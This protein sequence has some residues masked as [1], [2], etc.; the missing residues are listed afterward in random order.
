VNALPIISGAFGV[1][2]KEAVIEVGGY[3]RGHLGEDMELTMRLHR[4]FRRRR[5]RYRIVYAPD[6]VAWTEVPV[7]KDVLRKQR[8]R[9]HRGLMQV[10]WEYK[11]MLFD[12]RYGT[13]G[14]VSWPSFIAFEFFAPIIE[15]VGWFAIPASL[16]AGILNLEIA[17]PLILIALALGAVNSLVGLILDERFGYYNRA[18]EAWRLLIYSLGEQ[19]GLRQRTVWWRIRAMLWNPRQ[20]DWGD[21]E[22]TGVANLSAKDKVSAAS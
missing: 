22:R 7:T 17:V 9:W 6:A 3:R 2:Q 11:G 20:K 16:A 18:G 15:F 5:R 13:I 12:P 10:M 21:M 8:I 4:H 1:F 14:L 19:L